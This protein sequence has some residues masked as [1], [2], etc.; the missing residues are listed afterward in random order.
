MEHSAL[1]SRRKERIGMYLFIILVG[2][3]ALLALYRVGEEG[4]DTREALVRVG[5]GRD[6]LLG[7]TRGRQALVGSLRWAP[8]PTLLPILLLRVPGIEGGTLAVS[9]VAAV[10]AACLCVFLSRWWAQY[11]MREEIR[12]PIAFALFLSPPLLKPIFEGS[13]ETLFVF[14]VIGTVA[15]LIHW[16]ETEELRSLAYAAISA[17]LAPLVRYQGIVLPA[18]VMFLLLVHLVVHRKR[19]A[20]AEGTL[21]TFLVPAAYFVGLWYAGNWLIMGDGT[22]F[23]RGLEVFRDPSRWASL[24]VDQCEWGACVLPGLIGVLGWGLCRLAGK[25]STFWTGLPVL[26][27]CGLLWIEGTRPLEPPP[28]DPTA[29]QL[30]EVVLPYLSSAHRKDR[31]IISGYRGYEVRRLTHDKSMYLHKQSLY[32]DQALEQT[33]GK[34]LYLLVPAPDG[35]DRWE[36]VNLK[37]PGVFTDGCRGVVFEK[38]WERWSLWRVVRLDTPDQVI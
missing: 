29:T 8:L 15:H 32:M 17:G 16:W 30:A 7:A 25:K 24:L 13:A 2:T 10:G 27:A 3:G 31:I 26:A 37:Y 6:L 33:R 5:V 35:D 38:A 9:I 28:P 1:P 20:Y 34:R 4:P 18:F 14:L 23:L 11:G 36:D 12:V 22:F 19:E 21:I